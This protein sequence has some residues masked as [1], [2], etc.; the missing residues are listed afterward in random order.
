MLP[1]GNGLEPCREL[2]A[3]PPTAHAP[4]VMVSAQK[5]VK[6]VKE[7]YPRADFVP[8]PFDIDYLTEGSHPKLPARRDS[9]P[10]N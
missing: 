4:I 6:D 10:K 1:D 5:D 3:H 8:K 2:S 7:E 9:V